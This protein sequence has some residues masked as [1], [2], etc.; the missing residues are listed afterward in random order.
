MVI[1]LIARFVG[2]V[3]RGPECL[4]YYATLYYSI[5]YNTVM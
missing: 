1:I 5:L 4:L 3:P 2:V